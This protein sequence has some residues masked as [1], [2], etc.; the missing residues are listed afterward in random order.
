MHHKILLLSLGMLAALAA[1]LAA[2]GG[3]VLSGRVLT[4]AGEPAS[5][6][7]VRL[8]D[9]HRQVTTTDDGLFRFDGVPPGEYL[10]EALSE[11]YGTGAATAVVAGG[12]TTA[13]DILLDLASQV[14]EI[15]VTAGEAR[16]KLDLAQA[17]SS[18]AGEDLRLRLQ[19]S[20]GETL[21]QEP[22]VHSTYFAPGASRPVIRGLG[23]DR[24]RMLE[25]GVGT[26]DVSSTSPDHA[27]AVEPAS[28]ERIEVIRGPATLLYGSSAVGGVVNV[29]DQRIPTYRAEEAFSGSLEVR[30]G[31]VADERAGSLSL[32]GGGGA[33]AWHLDAG[34]RDGDDYAIPGFAAVN[35]RP[36]ARRGV[37]ENSAAEA[38][39]ATLGGSYFL[40]DKG[41]VGLSV[42]GTD[43]RYGLPGGE[44]EAIT[45]D[46]EQRRF[47][48]KSELTGAF[49]PFQ[50]LRIRLGASDYEHLELEGREIGTVFRNDAWEG[51]FE[52]VQAARGGWTGSLGLQLMERDLEA[53]GEE[54]F[55]K[56]TA[57]SSRALFAF[58]E[59]VRGDLRYQLGARFEQQ[60]LDV[61]DP[62]LPDRSFNGLSASAGLVWQASD[63]YSVAVSLARSTKLPNGEE[64][65]SDGLHVATRA[66]ELGDPRLGEETSLGLDLALRKEQGRLTGELTLFANRFDDFIF[67]EITGDV[68]EGFPVARFTQADADFTGAELELRGEIFAGEGSH[69]DLQLFGDVVRAELRASDQ[70]LPRI[71]PLRYGAGLHFHTERL[72]AMT[73]VRRVARQDRVAPHET[74]TAGYVLVNASVSYRFFLKDQVV[75]L[76][77]RGTNLGD[78]LARNH[79]SFVKDQV[80][81]PGRDFALSI[82]L[83]F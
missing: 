11:R 35:P 46:A 8:V 23:G 12:E 22:G 63:A 75:D 17:A 47:D 16:A 42:S 68:V 4:P 53:V 48:L 32:E 58:Q 27:V 24:V 50:G 36:G 43:S 1:P 67:E 72:H 18:L 73:E 29:I 62:L 77:L 57:T 81:L 21:A 51:R 60:D 83:L 2:D 14:D 76:L 25:G 56:P 7:V 80:P 69:L 49:G 15:I 41:Y 40:G 34:R 3:G 54:A 66:F 44:E 59:L 71:P 31:T 78:E 39:N 13:V 20:L 5:G 61:R 45:I 10:L 30:G 70:P 26:G 28:A 19:P 38:R 6:A 65:Y 37:L 55:I 52:A 74:P 82:R 79:V 64:L 33:W 9:L